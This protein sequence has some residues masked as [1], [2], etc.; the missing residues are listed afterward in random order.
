MTIHRK[1]SSH[2]IRKQA[3]KNKSLTVKTKFFEA[4]C[5]AALS[6]YQG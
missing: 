5:R 4:A 6:K 3:P 2:E 1:F